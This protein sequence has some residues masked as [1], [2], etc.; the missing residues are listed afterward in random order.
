[1]KD[2]QRDILDKITPEIKAEME[3]IWFTAD[4]HF[5]HPKIVDICNRPVYLSDK[6][7][8]ESGVNQ[9]DVSDPTYKRLINEAHNEW[10]V[11]EV[12]NKYVRKKDTLYIL[13]DVSMRDKIVT[14]KF[15]DRLN[16]DKRLIVG[17]H[18]RNI[19]KSTR[20]GEIT[21]IKDFNFS[22]KNPDINIHIV[23][24][25][26][27][28]LSW[29]R[30]VYGAWHLF[31]HVHGRNP[32]VGRSHDIGLDNKDN[33]WKPMNLYE[34]CHLMATKPFY[35]DDYEPNED[36]IKDMSPQNF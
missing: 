34:V 18:D 27:P 36:Q 12:I 10:L 1:M 35:D 24:C 17:N 30:R 2:V 11:K 5:G 15:L 16:G 20:F 4:L 32:G 7:L 3:S 25:H 31:G 9:K 29:N 21:L 22:R 14:D 23:L 6:V 33:L 28:M 26:Y 8:N 19:H 13:G